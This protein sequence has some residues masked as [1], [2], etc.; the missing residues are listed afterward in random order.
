MAPGLIIPLELLLLAGV[1]FL[2]LEIKKN[3]KRKRELQGD[4]SIVKDEFDTLNDNLPVGFFYLSEDGTIMEGNAE[5][6]NIIRAVDK[7]DSF[8]GFNVFSSSSLI[9]KSDIEHLKETGTLD[10]MYHTGNSAYSDILVR[11]SRI[12]VYKE[13]GYTGIVIDKTEDMATGKAR[14][15][16]YNMFQIAMDR[17]NIAVA[18]VNIFDN[19]FSATNAW[20]S[21]LHVKQGINFND[22]FVNAP[23]DEKVKVTNFMNRIRNIQFNED[24]YKQYYGY[25]IV[26]QG[27]EVEK[28]DVTAIIK[29][30]INDSEHYVKFYGILTEYSPDEGR[31]VAEIVLCNIDEQVNRELMLLASLQKTR[32]AQNLKNKSIANM[33]TE[34]KEPLNTILS[35]TEKIFACGDT[36]HAKN[37]L[38]ELSRSNEEL[39][40][41][42]SE[43]INISRV[44][45][46]AYMQNIVEIDPGTL[47]ADVV[48]EFRSMLRENVFVEYKPKKREKVII[49]SRMV[50]ELLRDLAISSAKRTSAGTITFYLREEPSTDFSMVD[51]FVAI[52]DTGTPLSKEEMQPDNYKLL[53]KRVKTKTSLESYIVRHI[54]NLLHGEIGFRVEK[55]FGK[56]IN[57]S[58][59]RFPAG[60]AKERLNN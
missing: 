44:E 57:T 9:S 22:S 42:I 33:S 35:N 54:S 16:M 51:L 52:S 58:W 30:V 6:A 19:S 55:Q 27:E 50:K 31:V 41:T 1:V 40:L 26:K 3:G 38:K 60:K 2:L 8:R 11:I 32:S 39:L 10:K 29:L 12:Q 14:T 7:K 49:D 17:A 4:Y 25:N 15:N 24:L 5:L 20:Y 56:D 36:A 34:I 43:V 47:V 45:S 48:A 28:V 46:A 53:S 21:I 23:P 13:T 59:C 18:T 37:L